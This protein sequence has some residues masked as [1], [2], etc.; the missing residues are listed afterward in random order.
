MIIITLSL[1]RIRVKPGRYF[2]R[3]IRYGFR[4]MLRGPKSEEGWLRDAWERAYRNGF[5]NFTLDEYKD[6]YV[7]LYYWKLK[8]EGV[9]HKSVSD[10]K[11]HFSNWLDNELKKQKD[12]RAKNKKL[13]AELQQIRQEKSFAAKL[14]QEQIYNLVERHKKTILQDFE[15]DLTNPAEYYA[16]RDLVRQLG[17]D[18]TGREFREFE[19]DENNS[20]VLS[21]L[22]YYFNGCRLA[23]KVFPDEDYKIHKNLLIVGAPGTG[24]T[25]IMQIFADYLRLTRNPSQF[26][27]LSVTQ[28]MNYY[29][30]NGHIDLY[31]YNEGQSKGFNPAPFNICLNDIGLETENQKSYGTSLDSVIDEFL[32]ARYEIYQ[33]FG[34]KYHITSNLNIGD[35]RK[36]FE[37]RLID[38]FKSFNVIPLLGNSRRR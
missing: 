1:A 23:E 35:F 32:Y 29:K 31:S 28:M 22:L 10:A 33:Q 11:R 9:T 26:E 12:D 19:V 25:M 36:R 16:H 37:G 2:S 14:K 4:Q 15:Y 24:K 7:D 8:G 13:S 38:R 6:E 30:M 3:N 21:F 5:R 20:K 18:Y 34:K 27:N 17:N